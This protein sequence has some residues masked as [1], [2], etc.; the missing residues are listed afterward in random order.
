MSVEIQDQ[1][2]ALLADYIIAR[3]G[4]PF[5]GDFRQRFDK[6]ERAFAQLPA[7]QS[8]PDLLIRSGFGVGRWAKVPWLVILDP[9]ETRTPQQ[10]VA[11]AL[12]FRQDMA[13][14]TLSLNQGVARDLAERGRKEARAAWRS[15]ASHART[16]IGDLESVGFRLDGDISLGQDDGHAASDLA[17]RTIAWTAYPVDALPDD[18][19]LNRLL[20]ALLVG[21]GRWVADQ[22][23]GH[24]VLAFET[25]ALQEMRQRFLTH[26]TGFLTFTD[27]SGTYRRQERDYKTQLAAIFQTEL[28]PLLTAPPEDA[29]QAEATIQALHQV[30][31]RRKVGE[32]PAIQNLLSWRATEHLGRLRGAEALEAVHL[33]RDLLSGTG[34]TPTRV[35]RFNAGYVAILA[36]HMPSGTQGVS[37]SLPTLLLMLADPAHEIF[38]RTTLFNDVARQL[39]CP[40]PLSDEHLNAGDYEACLRLASGIRTCLEDWGWQPQDMI[41]V[42]SFLWVAASGAYAEAPRD[43]FDDATDPQS[44]RRIFKIAPGEQARFWPECR[45]EG[46][47]C[48]GW[49]KVGDLREYP[50]DGQA[51]LKQAL[52]DA[53]PDQYTGSRARQATGT[54]KVKELWHFRNLQPGDIVLASRG[55]SEILAMGEVV[56]PGYSF[57]PSRTEYQHTVAVRWNDM[58]RRNLTDKLPPGV[59]ATWMN[60]ALYPVDRALYAAILGERPIPDS[61]VPP[62]DIDDEDTAVPDNLYIEPPFADTVAAVAAKKL[63]LPERLLRRYHVALKTRGFVILAGV[64]GTG[65]T[66]LAEAYAQAVAAEYLVV[67]VAPNWTSRE[68]LLGYV[69]PTSGEYQHTAFS[70]FLIRAAKAYEQA[71][72]K[73]SVRPFHVILDEMNL[74]RAEHYFADFL[75]ALELRNRH[76]QATLTLGDAQVGLFRNLVFVGTVNMDETTH[77]FAHKVYDRAQVIEVTLDRGMLAAHVAGQE[78]ADI[79]LSLWDALGSVAPFALRTADDI[80]AYVRR[81]TALG[82]TWQEAFDEAVLQKLLPRIRGFDPAL[83]ELLQKLVTLTQH[84]FPLSHAKVEQM[85]KGLRDGAVSFF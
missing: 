84:D 34:D 76:D 51:D 54:K 43:A 35:E 60:C 57:D 11:V 12:N 30:L 24:P 46:M 82:A 41:D 37:R 59:R 70:R 6:L 83:A 10:G 8:R 62:T 2:A 19:T 3:Q 66:W 67:P 48:I 4:A 78:Y 32:P 79:L 47:I 25:G 81:A 7:L 21:Y 49:D 42:Q 33:F 31:T 17:A 27:S 53:Y 45:R 5:P 44:E 69:S 26:M 39:G 40:R 38:V 77:G 52:R 15:R 16:L 58:Y 14:M 1:L 13:G 28:L 74:A 61:F 55:A 64:S 75:S 71:E 18:T 63:K 9:R 68:D 20:D 23:R 80:A 29:G 72:D 56:E 36:C 65:K 22:N 73:I 50:A 85:R